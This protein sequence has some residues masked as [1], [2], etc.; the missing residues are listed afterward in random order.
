MLSG[1][2]FTG[3]SI[4]SEHFSH[5]VA[6]QA[7]R[8][9]WGVHGIFLVKNPGNMSCASFYEQQKLSNVKNWADH[10]LASCS[11]LIFGHSVNLIDAHLL[12]LTI[13]NCVFECVTTIVQEKM[14]ILSPTFGYHW[15][16]LTGNL[17]SGFSMCCRGPAGAETYNG[18][19][20]MN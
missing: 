6:I 1:C 19:L 3:L 15:H 5:W 9:A 17:W 12:Y 13:V 8:C 11:V 16:R 7:S 18:S 2:R 20:P 4:F 10:C 14:L